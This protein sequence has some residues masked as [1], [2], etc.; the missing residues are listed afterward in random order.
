MRWLDRLLIAA[1][2]RLR[3]RAVSRLEPRHR[4]V[5]AKALERTWISG[6]PFK[7]H[8]TPHVDYTAFADALIAELNKMAE[9][10]RCRR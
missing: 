4:D 9:A 8:P 7:S 1:T 3:G 10:E 6:K 5:L 2:A